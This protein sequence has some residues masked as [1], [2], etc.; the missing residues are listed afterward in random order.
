M[1]NISFNYI[2]TVVR[3]NAMKFCSDFHG[4]ERMNVLIPSLFIDCHQQVQ[5]FTYLLKYLNISKVDWH[6][7]LYRRTC[8]ISSNATIMSKFKFV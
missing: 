8:Y 6:N 7:F 4:V 3:V 5:V 1:K 2:L